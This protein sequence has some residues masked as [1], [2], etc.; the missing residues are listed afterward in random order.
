MAHRDA[1]HADSVV[2]VMLILILTSTP[3][4]FQECP[5]CPP[6]SSQIYSVNRAFRFFPRTSKLVTRPDDKYSKESRP[7]GHPPTYPL[8]SKNQERRQSNCPRGEYSN[9]SLSAKVC[10]KTHSHIDSRRSTVTLTPCG[11]S[12]APISE[13]LSREW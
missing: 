10:L 12:T 6:A 13:T 11:W 7:D 8:C 2:G 3:Y 5:P 1:L 9:N 4:S